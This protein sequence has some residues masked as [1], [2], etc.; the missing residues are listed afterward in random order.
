MVEILEDPDIEQAVIDELT[1]FYPG[2]V[3]TSLPQTMPDTFIR[4]LA[5]GGFEQ[6]LVTGTPLFTIEVFAK[7]EAVAR[8][9]IARVVAI[10]QAAGRTGKLGTE[11]CYGVSIATLPQNYPHPSVPSHKRY[12]STLSAGIRRRAVTL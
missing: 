12:I 11:T 2:Q 7:R 5:V 6:N 4:V 3:G 10:L 1:V 9:V 8:P